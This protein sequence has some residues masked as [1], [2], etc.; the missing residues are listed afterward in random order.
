MYNPIASTLIYLAKILC[1]DVDPQQQIDP[2]IEKILSNLNQSSDFR[3]LIDH[4]K[5]NSITVIYRF[6]SDE[7]CGKLNVDT[8]MMIHHMRFFSNETEILIKESLPE[9]KKCRSVIMENCNVCFMKKYS[10]LVDLVK[11]GSLDKE[12][13][14]YSM[15]E[16][17]YGAFK[18]AISISKYID[19]LKLYSEPLYNEIEQKSS[20]TLDS[21][22]HLNELEGHT[23]KYRDFWEKIKEA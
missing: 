16:V 11:A 22:R 8:A 13:F 5:S 1:P 21:Y 19:S 17:E 15:E 23:E 9:V 7:E 12:R 4:Q 3:Q 10:E 20:E 6:L 14:A 2:R 18:Q